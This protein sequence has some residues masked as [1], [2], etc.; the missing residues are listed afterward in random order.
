MVTHWLNVAYSDDG[1]QVLWKDS[2]RVFHRGSRLGDD[3]KR[4]DVLIALPTADHPSRSSL[5]RFAH[6]Y[7]LKDELDATWA[8][9]P[10]DLLREANRTWCSRM[11][12]AIRSSGSVVWRQPH[13]TFAPVRRS[14]GRRR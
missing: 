8:V 6:E 11:R 1:S 12:P 14:V 5:E 9:P 10:L 4:R 13:S 2:E 7:D 3:G